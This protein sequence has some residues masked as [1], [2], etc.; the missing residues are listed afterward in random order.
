M[1]HAKDVLWY[2]SSF[3]GAP[4][5]E[6]LAVSH[7]AVA[8]SSGPKENSRWQQTY[9]QMHSLSPA[10]QWNVSGNTFILGMKY[11]SQVRKPGTKQKSLEV[12]KS[13]EADVSSLPG[14]HSLLQHCWI[15]AES[16]LWWHLC[17]SRAHDPCAAHGPPW[18]LWDAVM[19]LPFTIKNKQQAVG[20]EAASFSLQPCQAILVP[21]CTARKLGAA[22]GSQARRWQPGRI[23]KLGRGK[24]TSWPP[25]QQR[26]QLAVRH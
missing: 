7:R 1:S 10:M 22:Q 12:S 4:I 18:D 2:C 23:R 21:A 24:V 11:N 8:L 19:E 13:H 9:E 16:Q 26:M 20:I 17:S 25:I 3:D 14:T 15:P 6:G 5:P